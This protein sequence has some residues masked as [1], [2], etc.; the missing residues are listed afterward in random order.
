MMQV[1]YK[2]NNYEVV[3]NPES[4][5]YEV[6]NSATGF[7]EGREDALPKAMI[8]AHQF[9]LRIEEILLADKKEVLGAIIPFPQR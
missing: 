8:L 3:A 4:Q 9:S 7:I 1:M 2:N 5:L 6:I